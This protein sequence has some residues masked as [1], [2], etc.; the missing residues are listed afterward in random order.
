[1]WLRGLAWK[2]TMGQ[3]AMS[4]TSSTERRRRY[5]CSFL[6]FRRGF[7]ALQSALVIGG[8]ASSSQE[9]IEC[10]RAPIMGGVRHAELLA[11]DPRQEQAICR[12]DIFD[13]FGDVLGACSGTLVG[14]NVVLTAAHCLSAGR[15]EVSFASSSGEG[16]IRL[17]PV[18]TITHPTRDLAIVEL[19]AEVAEL[20]VVPIAIDQSDSVALNDWLQIAGFGVTETGAMGAL[21]FV[22]TSVIEVADATFRVSA[23][24]RAA[25]CFGDSGG[26]ALVR[27]PEGRMVVAGVLSL[28]SRSCGDSDEYERVA[29]SSAWIVDNATELATP[30]QVLADCSRVG[31]EGR[32]LGDGVL[33]CEQQTPRYERCQA[34]SVCGFDRSK[35]AWRCV[36]A[37]T[38]P[39]QGI[40]D[41]GRCDDGARVWCDAGTV[42]TS[43]C[44]ACGAQCV[45]SAANGQAICNTPMDAS[46]G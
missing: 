27:D 25:A 31:S 35:E 20:G 43:P 44:D 30:A 28:G 7:L 41:R 46:A 22:A 38:D 18:R 26:P 15:V 2:S 5:R 3:A 42:F 10:S 1:M 37:T 21:R 4:R 6:A 34:G 9:S 32:C 13:E 39:C 29:A 36:T 16:L 45:V 11:A 12:L 17:E 33:Y 8:C 24:R 23:E 14:D 19:P 40:G